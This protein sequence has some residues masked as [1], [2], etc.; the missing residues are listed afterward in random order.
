MTLEEAKRAINTQFTAFPLGEE[1]APL[2]EAYN[3]VLCEDV[4]STMDIPSFNR[5]TVDGYALKAEGTSGADE[6]TPANHKIV[7]AVLVGEQPKIVLGKGEAAEIVTGAPIPEGA[8]AVVMVED[9][10]REGDDLQVYVSL[11]QNENTMKKGSDI[12]NG[13]VIL[14]AGMVL[15]ATEIGVLA[16]LGKTSVKVSKMPIIAYCPLVRKSRSWENP[17]LQEKSMTS[18]RTASVLQLLSVG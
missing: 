2:L 3:R 16:A 5:S 12:K 7:G 13:E 6:N 9:T 18:T 14:K 4:I 1:H 8:D 15:G 11:T 10:E 17:C